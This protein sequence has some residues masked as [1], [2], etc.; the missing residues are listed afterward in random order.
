MGNADGQHEGFSH[1]LWVNYLGDRR[2]L[3]GGDSLSLPVLL[4]EEGGLHFLNGLLMRFPVWIIKELGED[5]G[6]SACIRWRTLPPTGGT[7]D[8][9]KHLL[10][11][12]GDTQAE[13]ERSEAA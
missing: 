7:A 2:L 11:P 8:H 12:A 5:R 13:A 6:F 4:I 3:C 9:K 1:F 10:L